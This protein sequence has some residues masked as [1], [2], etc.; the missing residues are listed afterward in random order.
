M[1][2]QKS[3]REVDSLRV[4]RAIAIS[5]LLACGTLCL[6]CNSSQP[7][8][9][10]SAAASPAPSAA[11]ASTAPQKSDAPAAEQTGG[12]DGQRAFDH[13]SKLVS[14][15]PHS[16]GSEGIRKAQEYIHTELQSFGCKYDDHDFHADTT[17]G[18]VAM[19]N[20]TAKIPGK[21]SDIIMLTTH[22]DTKLMPNFVGADDSGSSTGLMLELARH[23]CKQQNALTIWITFFDG[24][25][26]FTPEW[27]DGNTYGSREMAASMAISGD[28]KRVKA[29]LLA[30]MV[31]G[32]NLHIKRES[33]STKWLK[34][35]VWSTAS[36]LGYKDIFLPAETT[37][38]DDH[39]AFVHRGVPSV[40]VIDLEDPQTANYW[41]TT[42]DTLDKV[43]GR[44]LAIVGHVFLE[45][46]PEI[47]KHVGK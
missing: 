18:N 34:D 45:S 30:D 26:S 8:G 15:G 7:S 42:A 9:S 28:L 21:S 32:R 40:D 16:P 22:Y 12:F 47:E 25:E 6:S 5:A 29:F 46:I 35:I 24:E 33:Q 39:L 43:S 4:L 17:V 41:H 11:S 31:G 20:I 27:N 23:L 19:K 14:F 36:R 2:H 44:S 1:R 37:I 10:A 3:F 38:E 13:V